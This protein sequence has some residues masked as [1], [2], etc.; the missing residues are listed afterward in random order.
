MTP[1]Q[2]RFVEEYVQDLNATQAAIRAGFSRKT[3]ATAGSRLM[4]N[5]QI[6]AAVDKA[7]AARATKSEITAERVLREVAS[8]AFS[9]VG[10]IIDHSGPEPK[11]RPANEIPEAARRAISSVKIRR[12][13]TGKDQPDAE[14]VEFRL[15]NKNDA[16]EKLAKHLGLLKERVEHTGKDGKPIQVQAVSDEARREFFAQL[17]RALSPFPDAK[18]AVGKLLEAQIDANE[19]KAE[20]E[21]QTSE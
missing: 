6:Q 5:V 14:I 3:A 16:L 7:L 12:E 8:L 10:Q 4:R 18:Q 21:G 1:R 11:L 20:T 2:E 13:K 15:W 9:D 19:G 17:G